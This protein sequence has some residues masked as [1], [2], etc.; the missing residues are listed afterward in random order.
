MEPLGATG[1]P[2]KY[3]RPLKTDIDLPI[4]NEMTRAARY[5]VALGALVAEMR[6]QRQGTRQIALEN[7]ERVALDR[8]HIGYA[9]S[10]AEDADLFEDA[11]VDIRI[12]ART[13]EG[14]I[15]SIAGGQIIIAVEEDLGEALIRCTLV[16]D[17]TALL[18]A[19][20]E[21]LEKSTEGGRQLNVQLADDVVTNRGNAAPAEAPLSDPVWPIR[22]NEKQKDAVRLALANAV[23]YLW[24]PPGTGKTT[25]LS[26]LIQEL[27]ARGKRVLICSNTNRAVDQVLLSLCGALRRTMRR[28]RKE[29]FFALD[30]S[31][32]TS[33]GSNTRNTSLS[34]V[35]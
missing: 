2:S 8:G 23:I 21:K 24:G 5:A 10:F 11:R 14:N 25:T 3:I 31:H 35:S 22:F 28:W 18:E 29:R 1:R 16:I 12:G 17:N 4:T 30:A 20:K 6:R 27:F 9:F 33:C 13:I 32:M 34:K 19:L 15:V 7:G 26:V